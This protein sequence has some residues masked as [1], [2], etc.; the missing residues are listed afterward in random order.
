MPRL[1]PC[2]SCGRHIRVVERECRFCGRVQ[3]TVTAP[4]RLTIA[5]LGLSL[6][7]CTG[8]DKEPP[9]KSS[10]TPSEIKEEATAP[11]IDPEVPSPEPGPEPAQPEPAAG[12]TSGA[13]PGETGSVGTTDGSSVDEPM[14]EPKPKPT[15][16]YGGP[17]PTK[18]YG[19]P[20]PPDKDPFP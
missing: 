20:P 5:L 13:E 4:S 14:V 17:R 12:E 11:P 8:A 2:P 19:A 18:K 1:L 7:A 3:A 10:G 16:K 15:T 9:A 6:A